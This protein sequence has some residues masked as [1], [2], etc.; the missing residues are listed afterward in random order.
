[1]S[2][3]QRRSSPVLFSETEALAGEERLPLNRAA[4]GGLVIGAVSWLAMLHPALWVVPAVGVVLAGAAWYAI[5]R[6]DR[7]FR[8]G[9]LALIGLALC[10]FFMAYAP[11]RQVTRQQRL[12]GESE[13]VGREWLTLVCRGQ[14]REAHQLRLRY[15]L[16]TAGDQTLDD[17]YKKPEHEQDLEKFRQDPVVKQLWGA[18]EIVRDVPSDNSSPTS[19]ITLIANRSATTT[20]DGDDWIKQQFLV[21]RNEGGVSRKVTVNIETLRLPMALTAEGIWMVRET[22]AS[23][24]NN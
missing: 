13:R 15:D 1:M 20:V 3:P 8:G 19:V 12:Y 14:L 10:V 4:V 18:G 11:T 21:E 6:S 24:A 2:E 7:R 22:S 9:R 16:R 5:E 17:F 23:T